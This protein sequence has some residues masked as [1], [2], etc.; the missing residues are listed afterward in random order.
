MEIM[1]FIMDKD[2]KDINFHFE[3]TAHLLDREMLDFISQA[4]EGLFQFEIGVQSTNLKTLEAIGRTTDLEKL[5]SI[6]KEIKNNENIHQHL[7]L[8]VGLPYENYNSFKDS[9]NE[10][11]KI[12]PEKKSN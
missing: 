6:T 1:N 12:K 4:K 9:F 11:Y 5:K 2:P 7:D 8:I 10:V 3:V